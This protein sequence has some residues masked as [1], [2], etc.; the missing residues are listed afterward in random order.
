MLS[1]IVEI[2]VPSAAF[3]DEPA[4]VGANGDADTVTLDTYSHEAQ[5]LVEA[6]LGPKVI[7]ERFT[8]EAV[9]CLDPAYL[10]Q[11]ENAFDLF[12]MQNPALIPGNADT[13]DALHSHLVRTS[14]DKARV[15]LELRTQLNNLVRSKEEMEKDLMKKLREAARAKAESR[16]ELTRQLERIESSRRDLEK[17]LRSKIS[18][19][20]DEV[21]T[22]Q[23]RSDHF[24]LSESLS[25]AS[26][27]S[28]D[29][30]L[31]HP[32][33]DFNL[34]Y[35]RRDVD[36]QSLSSC[37]AIQSS[38][39]NVQVPPSHYRHESKSSRMVAGKSVQKD[40]EARHITADSPRRLAS[41]EE[42]DLL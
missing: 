4:L 11:F 26:N 42:S 35:S 18:S 31:G 32:R 13:I 10:K 15:E 8:N 40:A 24:G 38:S 14:A 2:V 33:R 7:N 37:S 12:L 16:V 22:L 30:L 25:V 6:T 34:G 23:N 1:D 5:R 3:L 21:S 29:M 9:R 41:S 39:A 17:S 36:S 28:S 27:I 20:K 19:A